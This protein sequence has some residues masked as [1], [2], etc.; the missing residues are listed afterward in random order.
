MGTVEEIKIEPSCHNCLNGD[1]TVT[2]KYTYC[3][4]QKCFTS[5][6]L[7]WKHAGHYKDCKNWEL[8]KKKGQF[9]LKQQ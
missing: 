1:S 3:K 2:Y 7:S 5:V 8:S 6:A 4:F 9:K